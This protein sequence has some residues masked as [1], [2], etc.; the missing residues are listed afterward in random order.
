[1]AVVERSKYDW[2]KEITTKSMAVTSGFDFT[3]VAT[4]DMKDQNQIS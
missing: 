4:P 1:M 3:I 2:E